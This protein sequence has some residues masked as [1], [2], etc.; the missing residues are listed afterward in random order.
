MNIGAGKRMAI[1]GHG[2]AP[3]SRRWSAWIP[4]IAALLALLAIP[5]VCIASMP[6]PAECAE[7]GDF[8]RNAALARDG[9]ISEERFIGQIRDDVL[10]I[11]GFPPQLRWFVQD[12]DDAEFLIAAAT[13][14]FR[15]PREAR[16]HQ[17]DFVT[18][19]LGR[20]A[21]AAGTRL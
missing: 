17:G 2:D 9:G 10:V 6:S 12:D 1:A 16:M 4:R 20:T 11:Q 13:D 19:C 18:A 7:A 14:V 8:I 15:H 21:P 5:A 3:P